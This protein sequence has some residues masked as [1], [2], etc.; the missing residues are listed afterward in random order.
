M[1]QQQQ[2]Q[3]LWDYHWPEPQSSLLCV[4]RMGIH[5]VLVLE[6]VFL[7]TFIVC[8]V[9]FILCVIDIKYLCHLLHHIQYIWQ[10][11]SAFPFLL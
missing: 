2:Q 9:C 5:L 11:P 7:I 6:V 8:V 1:Q 3:H 4:G 10:L